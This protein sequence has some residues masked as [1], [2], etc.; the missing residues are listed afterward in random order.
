MFTFNQERSST[1]P[2]V[3]STEGVDIPLS[4]QRKS[5]VLCS[6]QAPFPFFKLHQMY[7]KVIT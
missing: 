4:R 2:K 1:A 5:A 3:F 6:F 7:S